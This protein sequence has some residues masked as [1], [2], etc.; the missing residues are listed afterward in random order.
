MNEKELFNKLKEF[1]MP[2]LVKSSGVL[3]SMIVSQYKDNC[4]LN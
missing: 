4:S 1:Y 2:D 3:F